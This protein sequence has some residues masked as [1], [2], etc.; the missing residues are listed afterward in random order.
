LVSVAQIC[1]ILK[2]VTPASDEYFYIEDF[3]NRNFI[4]YIS[5]PFGG[6]AIG[7]EFL[8]SDMQLNKEFV[9]SLKVNVLVLKLTEIKL[10]KVEVVCL[11]GSFNE[12]SPCTVHVRTVRRREFR[13]VNL[14]LLRVT[15]LTQAVY[16]AVTMVR[17]KSSKQTVNETRSKQRVKFN[18][19]L[20]HAI[21][22]LLL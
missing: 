17:R 11:L 3:S 7:S 15:A 10:F 18:F 19:N 4:L 12:F 8:S 22:F 13:A 16:S 14:K 5:I 2:V 9:C 1:K 20:F 6:R 21:M